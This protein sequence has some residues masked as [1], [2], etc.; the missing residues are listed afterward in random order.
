MMLEGQFPM[1][2]QVGL[3]GVIDSNF[4][5]LAKANFRGVTTNNVPNFKKGADLGLQA[6][7][8]S[9]LGRLSD[10]CT[11]PNCQVVHMMWSLVPF[12]LL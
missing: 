12:F 1:K 5:K 9:P 2:S 6:K 3:F 7:R 10:R 11:E 4:A 8:I